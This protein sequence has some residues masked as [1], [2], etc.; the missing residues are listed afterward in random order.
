M[1][2]G[3]HRLHKADNACGGFQMPDIGLDRPDQQRRLP[4][5]PKDCAEGTDL[6][7]ITQ[8]GTGAMRFNIGDFGRGHLRGGKGLAQQLL[9]RQPVG[10]GQ[11]AAGAIMV[12]GAAFDYGQDRI[13]IPFGIT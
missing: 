8:R 11:P 13:A 9:L 5:L 12:N 1:L 2:D 4:F 3:E 6:N 10:H 7:W